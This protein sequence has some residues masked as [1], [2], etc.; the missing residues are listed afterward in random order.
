MKVTPY[1][2]VPIGIGAVVDQQSA[3]LIVM[4]AFIPLKVTYIKNTPQFNF[5][6]AGTVLDLK[7]NFKHVL[8]FLHKFFEKFFVSKNNK[9]YLN[10]LFQTFILTYYS[11]IA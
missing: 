5:R 3:I 8:N 4:K 2:P 11:K 6:K 9:I 1:S 10:E 7:E